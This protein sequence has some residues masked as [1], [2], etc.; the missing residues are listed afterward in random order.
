[1]WLESYT[2]FSLKTSSSR[3]Q[4]CQSVTRK[5]CKLRLWRDRLGIKGVSDLNFIFYYVPIICY[6]QYS[7]FK[8]GVHG[9]KTEFLLGH[10]VQVLNL[11]PTPTNLAILMVN[12]CCNCS[13]FHS[14]QQKY[15]L[16]IT[17][18]SQ[19]GSWFAGMSKTGDFRSCCSRD[20]KGAV[21]LG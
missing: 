9:S 10:A 8:G 15:E 7:I 20:N 2:T 4:Q 1:M 18:L 14:S 11:H 17:L 16:M 13:A 21:R 12:L 5:V 3:H 19:L 6:I